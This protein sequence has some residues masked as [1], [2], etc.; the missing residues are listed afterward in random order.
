MTAIAAASSPVGSPAKVIFSL[1]D[2]CFDY[3]LTRGERLPIVEDA[4]LELRRGEVVAILGPSGCGKST[5]LA[6]AA[7]LAQCR[8]GSVTLDGIDTTGQPGRAGFMMQRDELLPWRTVLGNVLLGPEV[9]HGRVTAADARRATELL[10]IAG[11]RGF[12]DHYP[13]A[14]SGGMRQRAAFVR[15]LMLDRPLVLL[16]EPF[17]ALD[18]ITRAEM[19]E[20]LLRMREELDLTL[21]MVTHDVDE[22]IFLSD[23][24]LVMSSRPGRFVLTADVP[25]SRPR[26]YER[27]VVQTAFGALK[28]KLLHAIRKP[29]GLEPDTR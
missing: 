6:I 2:V 9:V 16:D 20:W 22:A 14:L 4:S 28:S 21:L 13:S 3:P 24:V 11:L 12:E 29:M 7:G 10:G 8:S 23:R 15:T 27:I 25:F 17:G 19:Q 18:A 5:L 1:S 26:L